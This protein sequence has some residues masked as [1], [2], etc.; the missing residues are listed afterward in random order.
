MQQHVKAKRK[1]ARP[2]H[3]TKM[4]QKR[5]A[6]PLKALKSKSVSRRPWRS[7]RGEEELV[8][9]AC[10]VRRQRW[11]SQM[12]VWPFT[13]VTEGLVAVKGISSSPAYPCVLS[14]GALTVKTGS[15]GP[16]HRQ[17]GAGGP[18]EKA[19]ARTRRPEGSPEGGGFQP[20][21]GDGPAEGAV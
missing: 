21:P 18:S 17:R 14:L 7:E 4:R 2:L 13:W 19:G 12:S 10:G 1:G 15:S 9:A 6:C 11:G 8:K 20:R 5:Q 3:S 16:A